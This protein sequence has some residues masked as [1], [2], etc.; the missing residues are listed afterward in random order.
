[1]LRA[2]RAEI[3]ENT[4]NTELAAKHGLSLYIET[5]NHKI[6]FDLGP[7]HT[8]FEN[9]AKRDIN[10]SAIDTVI[11]SH[12]HMDHGGALEQFLKVNSSAK[13]Y[14]QRRAFY[15]HFSKTLFLKVPVGLKES[16]QTNEQVVLLDGGYVIDDELTLFTVDKTDRCH[17]PMND[18]LYERSEKDAFLHEQNLIISEDKVAL[19]MGCGH[20]GVV[21]IMDKAGRYKPNIC[22]GG[23]HLFNPVTKKSVSEGLLDDIAAELQKHTNTDF[24]TCHCTGQKAYSYLSKKM[25]NLHYISCGETIDLHK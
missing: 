15:P 14:V 11:I 21:N 5:K 3:V 2:I 24:Y 16:L 6:L 13:I 1:M 8:L 22:V 20:A 7:D 19:F 9:A 25:K 4:S 12:G 10:L 17:S 23:F 18:V